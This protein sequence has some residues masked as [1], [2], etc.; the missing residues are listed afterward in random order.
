MCRTFGAFRQDRD[1]AVA[2]IFA[3][4]LFV[5]VGFAG[6]MVDAARAYNAASALDA[7]A[8]AAAKAYKEK[9]T[10]GRALERL[11][12][13]YFNA[14]IEKGGRTKLK[15]KNLAVSID[16][17]TEAVTVTVDGKVKTIFG[18]LFN[19]KQLKFKRSSTALYEIKDLELSLAL[20]MSGSMADSR[21]PR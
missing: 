17:E 8:L 11:A 14:N 12:K 16:P 15:Y 6:L 18:G 9:G 4:C 13:K 10:N 3:G 7:T 5:L 20:D 2:I 1:G 19:V 21:L